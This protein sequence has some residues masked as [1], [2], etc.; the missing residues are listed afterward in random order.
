MICAIE[1]VCRIFGIERQLR[2]AQDLQELRLLA[3]IALKKAKLPAFAELTNDVLWLAGKRDNDNIVEF[4]DFDW[5]K[6]LKVFLENLKAVAFTP[7]KVDAD[8]WHPRAIELALRPWKVAPTYEGADDSG[9]VQFSGFAGRSPLPYSELLDFLIKLSSSKSSR[10]PVKCVVASETQQQA[11]RYTVKVTFSSSF[12]ANENAIERLRN[13][14]A[15]V[16]AGLREWRLHGSA[17]GNW[18]APFV[19]MS[20]RLLGIVKHPATLSGDPGG[21]LVLCK[22]EG[23]RER[24][25]SFTGKLVKSKV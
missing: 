18:Q 21:L 14:I 12:D 22:K 2:S 5:D 23:P 16:L 1:A 15:P 8:S 3:K 20:N 11:T 10:K 25:D 7:F 13:L 24:H 6:N 4:P 19:E 17:L 9:V